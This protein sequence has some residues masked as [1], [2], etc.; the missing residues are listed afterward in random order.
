VSL[1]TDA[2]VEI[3]EPDP[4][5]P[6]ARVQNADWAFAV[7][8]RE[9]PIDDDLYSA[10]VVRLAIIA[11]RIAA[12]VIRVASLA[13][14]VAIILVRVA[15]TGTCPAS[16][17][18][19]VAC[20]EEH[21]ATDLAGSFGAG[22]NLVEVEQTPP[23]RD[24]LWASL[25]EFFDDRRDERGSGF[26]GSTHRRVHGERRLGPSSAGLRV[27]TGEA[28]FANTCFFR[29]ATRLFVAIAFVSDGGA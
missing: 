6:V 20:A 16:V 11:A 1:A 4:A 13:V 17:R 7:P 12:I 2:K 27:L 5:G 25:V 14:R 19:S 23:G 24:F 21:G 8:G 28:C 10:T 26:R 18:S 9:V 15:I 3:A 22:S 29:S